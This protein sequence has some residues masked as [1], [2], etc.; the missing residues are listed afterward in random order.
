VKVGRRLA[1]ATAE[2]RTIDGE[3]V[4]IHNVTYALR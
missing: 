2:T 4:A 1:I 3:L